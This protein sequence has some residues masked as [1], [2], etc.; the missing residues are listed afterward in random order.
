M[1]KVNHTMTSCIYVFYTL[2][3]LWWYIFSVVVKN[4]SYDVLI[5]SKMFCSRRMEQQEHIRGTACS[6]FPVIPSNT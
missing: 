3:M 1:L 5:L 2:Y 6:L 4:E